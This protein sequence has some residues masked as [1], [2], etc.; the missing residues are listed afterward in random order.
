MRALQI[1]G[2]VLIVIGLW[3]IIRP[4]SY[5]REESGFKL[6]DIEAKMQQEHPVPGWVGGI[7]LGAGAVL[8]VVGIKKR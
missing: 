7:A 2:A 3:M 1:S 6:G 4:P 8:F 5:S